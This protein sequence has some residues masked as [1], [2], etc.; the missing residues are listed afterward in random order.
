MLGC[1]IPKK[2]SITLLTQDQIH[3]IIDK[4][5]GLPRK[6]LGYETPESL[7]EKELDLIYAL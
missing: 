4:I 6:I 1:F 3:P 7:F 2:T 5:N